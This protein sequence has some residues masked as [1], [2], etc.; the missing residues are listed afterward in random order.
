LARFQDICCVELKRELLSAAECGW[1]S[2]WP[3]ITCSA[4]GA[5][6]TVVSS[7]NILAEAVVQQVPDGTLSV[8]FSK[9][10]AES[11]AQGVDCIL[12]DAREAVRNLRLRYGYVFS[13]PETDDWV[14]PC[15]ES[16]GFHAV[17]FIQE[18]RCA[19]TALHETTNTAATF[20]HSSSV[21][22]QT[23]RPFSQAAFNDL[24]ENIIRQSADLPRLPAP[25]AVQ[26]QAMWSLFDANVHVTVAMFDRQPVGVAVL[27][28]SDLTADESVIV[29]YFGIHS[30]FRRRGIGCDLLRAATASFCRKNSAWLT[31]FVAAENFA[32]QSFFKAQQF[33]LH[34][35]QQLWATQLIE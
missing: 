31:S 23:T 26:L 16:A 30:G 3:G 33:E 7:G 4:C 21:P 27:S 6:V 13:P 11:T 8:L 14:Q 19:W 9:S 32:A 5:R 34:S 2:A 28:Q 1:H 35:A 20:W 17:E 15:F 24:L 25:T 29:E 18:F 10:L 12:R 22:P